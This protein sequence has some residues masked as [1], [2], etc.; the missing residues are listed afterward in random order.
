M[1]R[2][3]VF[4]LA[5]PA[6]RGLAHLVLLK[7]GVKKQT[8]LWAVCLR[9]WTARH[10]S[11][12]YGNSVVSHHVADVDAANSPRL[13]LTAMLN[14][15]FNMYRNAIILNTNIK[16]RDKWQSDQEDTEKS[17]SESRR[18]KTS[19]ALEPYFALN[20]VTRCKKHT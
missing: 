18:S 16:S 13:S 8:R 6:L 11:S 2:L 5:L 14:P 15:M 4:L 3:F 7:S 20:T 19:G 1:S 17:R 9:L 12:V 10:L